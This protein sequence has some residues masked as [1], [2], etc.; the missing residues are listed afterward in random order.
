MRRTAI[1]LPP[2][3]VDTNNVRSLSD[4]S[5]L[6][7]LGSG[8]PERSAAFV[9][10]FQA[11]VFGLAMTIVGDAGVAEEVAQ[12]SLLRVWR[13]ADAYDPSRGRVLT[14]LLTITRNVALDALRMRQQIPMD[15]GTISGLVT[16]RGQDPEE[17]G[18]VAH[19]SRRLR[20][21]LAGLPEEQRRAILLAAYFGRTAREIGDIE[22]IPLG[23][24][25]TRIRTA[26]LKIREALEVRNGR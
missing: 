18:L 22:G 25:K 5:L 8:D 1:P 19:E 26:M 3:N 13:H 4:E 15:P 17:R 7:G 16:D 23:T 12:E 21:I 24:A 10:R 2:R 11:R 20:M 14:W 9:R 6:A